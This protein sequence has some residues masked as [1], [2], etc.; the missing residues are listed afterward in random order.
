VIAC[1]PVSYLL[2]LVEAAFRLRT[3]NEVFNKSQGVIEAFQ[4]YSNAIGHAYYHDLAI[5]IFQIAVLLEDVI[6]TESDCSRYIT[7][8]TADL[9][10]AKSIVC[11]AT[12][13][14]L[15]SRTTV[16]PSLS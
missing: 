1:Q 12:K 16:F 9:G 3:E 4:S 8:E 13:A 11:K 7:I 14:I 2:G 10:M 5:V 15:R 6:P